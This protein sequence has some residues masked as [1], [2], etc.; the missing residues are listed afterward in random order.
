LPGGDLLLLERKFG[1]LIGLSVRIR[2]IRLP[3]VKPGTLIDGL[4]LFEADLGHQIDNMEGLSVHEA[5]N[6]EVVFEFN[7]GR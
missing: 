1:W 3:L 4:V 6:G 2:R 5:A 7:F